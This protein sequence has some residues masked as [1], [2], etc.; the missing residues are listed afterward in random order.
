MLLTFHWSNV[1]TQ[2]AAIEHGTVA[3]QHLPKQ[4][5]DHSSPLAVKDT[6]PGNGHSTNDT[7]L[8]T[9][10]CRPPPSYVQKFFPVSEPPTTRHVFKIFGRLW[11]EG[12][13]WLQAVLTSKLANLQ[14]GAQTILESAGDP[15]IKDFWGMDF[16]FVSPPFVFEML[17]ALEKHKI[18]PQEWDSYEVQASSSAQAFHTIHCEW[19]IARPALAMSRSFS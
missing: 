16:Y 5:D 13:I 3:I 19:N 9:L 18:Y 10:R 8:L 12:C 6:A 17:L 15:L 11:G 7:P 14:Y 1:N 4:D 2:A